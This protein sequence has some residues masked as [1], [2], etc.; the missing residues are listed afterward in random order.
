M[1]ADVQPYKLSNSFQHYE[2]TKFN[3]PE[4]FIL[5]NVLRNEIFQKIE[6]VQRA[7][8]LSNFILIC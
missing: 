1:F 7:P 3:I 2:N 8:H 4:G 5:D 6:S